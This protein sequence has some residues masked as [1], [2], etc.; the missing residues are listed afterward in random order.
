V[1]F[2]F[3]KITAAILVLAILDTNSDQLNRE[4]VSLLVIAAGTGLIPAVHN[5][6]LFALTIS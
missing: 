1:L 6:T 4:S 5:L 3:V 2:L